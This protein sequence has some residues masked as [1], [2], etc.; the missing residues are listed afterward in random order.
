[1]ESMDL[2]N[3]VP[4]GGDDQLRQYEFL[5]GEMQTFAQY[6]RMRLDNA[7][8]VEGLAGLLRTLRADLNGLRALLEESSADETRQ[9]TD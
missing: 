4:N 7:Q 1:M 6:S 5:L 2:S 8:S 3:A 9:G